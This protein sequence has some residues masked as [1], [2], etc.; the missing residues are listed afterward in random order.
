M[1]KYDF[2]CVIDRHGTCA[3]KLDNLDVMFGRHDV[4]PLWI[5]D[6]DF[7][8]CPDITAALRRRLDHPVLGYSAAPDSYWQ[9]II[10]WQR[11][12]HGFEISR[13]ELTF[14][15]GVVKGIALAVNYFTRQG[16]G[17]VIQP[18]VYHPFRMVIEGNEREVVENPLVFENGTYRMDL[19]GL[20]RMIEERRPKMMILCNPH[21]PVGLQWDADTLRR[22]AAIC[23]RGGVTVVSDEIHGDLMLW[24][25]R[26]IPFA[27]VSDDA[28]AISVT[29][30]APSKTF[31]IPG[32]VSS[33]M[34]VKD[35][36]LRRGF[37]HWL[38]VNEFNAPV[39]IST[40]GAEAAYRHGGQWL[41]E[42]LE[43]VQQ[44]IL[45][46]NDYLNLHVPGVH[47][48][49]PE[50]SFLVWL[51]FRDL[52]LKQDE[53]MR[54]LLERAHLALND[55]SMFGMQGN[56]FMRL[57]VGTPRCVLAEAMEHI[58]DA[59]ASLKTVEK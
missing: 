52:G 51:D 18:P 35:P 20:E 25:G 44:N 3:T 50:A 22:V 31:N 29:L 2:D 27:S 48:V 57:N 24:G 54:L 10:D 55:G 13:E 8:V 5:A 53:L 38:E 49:R 56:G 47:A 15:P 40:I 58:R 4:T 17:I 16:D 9:S 34:V 36:V 26:H 6:L 19:E 14:V 28:R 41:D 7:A 12:R 23:R 46:V 37:Y 43:Y 59:V 45:W 33:W 32:L 21:N 11:D 42:M 30:G 1:K 39:L